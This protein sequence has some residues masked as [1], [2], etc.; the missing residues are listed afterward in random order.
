MQAGHCIDSH[1]LGLRARM[2]QQI[3]PTGKQHSSRVHRQFTHRVRASLV[4][5]QASGNTS[6][7]TAFGVCHACTSK[8][9]AV[10]SLDFVGSQAVRKH[11]ACCRANAVHKP[12]KKQ[13][14]KAMPAERWNSKLQ[15]HEIRQFPKTDCSPSSSKP[16]SFTKQ[17]SSPL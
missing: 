8:S 11:T 6:C 4:G 13:R 9:H 16:Q 3:K 10:L 2:L 5:P 12:C 15:M 7:P 1:G 14:L 17:R